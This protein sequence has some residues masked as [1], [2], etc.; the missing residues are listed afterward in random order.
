MYK[1]IFQATK[2]SVEDFFQTWRT[3]FVYSIAD[4]DP[5][6]CRPTIL[7][8]SKSEYP[9]VQES[10]MGSLDANVLQ[11]IAKN[12]V[13]HAPYSC[14]S[15]GVPVPVMEHAMLL[16]P[17]SNLTSTECSL[18]LSAEI[19]EC[20]SWTVPYLSLFSICYI[21]G[22]IYWKSSTSVV[23]ISL[24]LWFQVLQVCFVYISFLCCT[25][26]LWYV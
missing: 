23:H 10:M 5:A 1:A 15:V 2:S 6:S 20:G 22:R 3:A 11:M 8:R 7:H 21:F 24:H 4:N 26:L 19:L 12:Y 18:T 25:F 13:I 16:A 17:K 14:R 9:E